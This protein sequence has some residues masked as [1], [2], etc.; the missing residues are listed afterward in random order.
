MRYAPFDAGFTATACPFDPTP[1]DEATC[2][3]DGSS[4]YRL[5]PSS[6]EP[7]LFLIDTRNG[8][9]VSTFSRHSWQSNA[10]IVGSGS[11]MVG[12]GVGFWNEPEKVSTGCA[13]LSAVACATGFG[14][15]ATG[16]ADADIC[17]PSTT[18]RHDT[19]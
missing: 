10:Q 6:I 17:T 12:S 5:S 4:T 19:A 18:T 3:P 1:S 9:D 7:V 13:S 2:C 11:E 14:A 15:G 8:V 16:S